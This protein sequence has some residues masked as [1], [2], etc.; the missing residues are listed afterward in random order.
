MNLNLRA[1]HSAK[2]LKLPGARFIKILKLMLKLRHII[3]VFVSI[4][5]MM[6]LTTILKL[7]HKLSLEFIATDYYRGF[8][9]I[10]VEGFD[11]T[12]SKM[13]KSGAPNIFGLS[14]VTA[15]S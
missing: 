4:D 2:C 9:E 14:P 3:S 5:I 10:T 8:I 7:M 15:G 1:R 13:P 12:L 6:K 11:V